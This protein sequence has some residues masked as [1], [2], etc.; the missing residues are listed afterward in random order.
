MGTFH[1][2]SSPA[3]GSN[4][5][6][7]NIRLIYYELISLDNTVTVWRIFQR[8][9]KYCQTDYTAAG[10]NRQCVGDNRGGQDRLRYE[11]IPFST[12]DRP[13]SPKNQNP[14]NR[15]LK[16]YQPP[17]LLVPG[18]FQDILP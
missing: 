17:L 13:K 14:Y 18:Q 6:N 7:Q 11:D 1:R 5:G 16:N 4:V 10:Y 12:Q 9:C 3:T 8:W 15:Q 2:F